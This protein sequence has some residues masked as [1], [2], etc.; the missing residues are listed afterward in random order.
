MDRHSH[1]HADGIQAPTESF[2]FLWIHRRDRNCTGSH[3][4]EGSHCLDSTFAIATEREGNHQATLGACWASEPEW[5]ASSGHPHILKYPMVPGRSC[6][7][8]QGTPPH[9]CDSFGEHYGL[10]WVPSNLSQGYCHPPTHTGIPEDSKAYPIAAPWHFG[11]SPWSHRDPQRRARSRRRPIDLSGERQMQLISLPP[12]LPA[13]RATLGICA[14]PGVN[15]LANSN[16]FRCIPV[17]SW[18]GGWQCK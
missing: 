18:C 3:L 1:V 11:H 14:C 2:A 10:R 6:H 17:S 4:A 15:M 7:S 5:Q 16:P 8:S 12:P 13:F 9:T